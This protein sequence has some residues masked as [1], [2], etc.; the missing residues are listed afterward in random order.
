MSNTVSREIWFKHDSQKSAIFDHKNQDISE[1]SHSIETGVIF[2]ALWNHKLSRNV[3]VM[4]VYAFERNSDWSKAFCDTEKM[5][6]NVD[7]SSFAKTRQ[8]DSNKVRGN[9]WSSSGR[10]LRAYGCLWCIWFSFGNQYFMPVFGFRTSC[11]VHAH[12]AC[13][14]ALLCECM[15]KGSTS[16][17]AR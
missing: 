6:E 2:P 3:T 17:P 11:M 13:L 12:H 10:L 7:F 15:G 4:S 9:S 14:A 16:H 1:S 8:E 5:I